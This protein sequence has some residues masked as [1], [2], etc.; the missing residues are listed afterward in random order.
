MVDVVGLH[1]AAIIGQPGGWSVD[2]KL[3]LQEK[4]LSAERSDRPR[5]WSSLDRCV[6]YLK[7]ELHIVRFE[8]LDATNYSDIAPMG[9]GREEAIEGDSEATAHDKWFRDQ[10]GAAII[11]ADDPEAEWVTNE[12]ANGSWATKRAELLKRAETNGK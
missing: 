3:G 2:L 7:K 9:K 1:G 8:L 10:V 6:E 12:E 5:I 11:E 4:Q